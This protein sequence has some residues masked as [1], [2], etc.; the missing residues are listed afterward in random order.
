MEPSPVDVKDQHHQKGYYICDCHHK[1]VTTTTIF[2]VAQAEP[3]DSCGVRLG[4]SVLLE[5]IVR[6]EN[7]H[8]EDQNH[9]TYKHC[10]CESLD[11]LEVEI[12]PKPELFQVLGATTHF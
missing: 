6:V 9:S 7:Q 8:G 4:F 10:N 12:H 3:H 2:E 11:E 1:V 5:A